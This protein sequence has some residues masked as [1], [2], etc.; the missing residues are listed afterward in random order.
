MAKM[1]DTLKKYTREIVVG[2]VVSLITTFVI[3]TWDWFAEV[4]PRVGAG[5]I[6]IIDNLTYVLAAQFT[7]TALL[8]IG[9]LCIFSCF[10]GV[11]LS[12]IGGGFATY[13]QT[14][15]LEQ[16]VKK[17]PGGQ[18]EKADQALYKKTITPQK[19]NYI[20]DYISRGKR[21]GRTALSTTILILILYALLNTCVL[22]PSYLKEKFTQDITVIAPYVGNDV[23]LKLNSDWILMR[24]R[25]AYEAIYE[26]INDV[27]DVNGLTRDK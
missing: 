20:Q 1:K 8:R 12:F 11:A 24:D 17:M 7:S 21:V 19:T 22:R 6:E 23:V 9:F 14:R 27:K 18:M 4:A 5:I 26:I 16:K 25:D 10:V 13:F 3:K 2:V 15:K